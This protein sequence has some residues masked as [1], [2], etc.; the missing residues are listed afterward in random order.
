M[1]RKVYSTFGSQAKREGYE[2]YFVSYFS[3]FIGHYTVA[4]LIA[5]Y[6]QVLT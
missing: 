3:L 5:K 1:T 2:F 4:G 6:E